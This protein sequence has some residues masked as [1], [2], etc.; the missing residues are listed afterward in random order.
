MSGLSKG[1]YFFVDRD[2]D[3]LRGRE[4][5][6]DIF[7]T[8]KYSIENY[9]V[10]DVVLNELLKNEFNCHL[11][12]AHAKYIREEF[13][14]MWDL[15]CQYTREINF[16]LFVMRRLGIKLLSPLPEKIGKIANVQLDGVFPVEHDVKVLVHAQREPSED[17]LAGLRDEFDGLDKY[18][19]YRGK[20]ALMFFMK[21]LEQL[22]L[23]YNSEKPRLFPK[24]PNSKVHYQKVGIDSL[25]SKSNLPAGLAE[26]LAQVNHVIH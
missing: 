4:A 19:R 17:E 2:F 18:A 13:G 3:D 20:F 22:A 16:R 23:D 24:I 26:F 25:A 9:L 7:V 21:W 8:D 1:V 10:D 12:L 6:N 15:F 14:R 11:A 5:S